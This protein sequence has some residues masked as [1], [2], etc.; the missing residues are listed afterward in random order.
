MTWDE[1]EL[2]RRF[3]CGDRAGFDAV[4]ERYA[5]RVM[6]FAR[7]L[8]GRQSEAEDLVQEVFLAA[9][10]ARSTFQGRS[11]LLTWL[12]G[13]AARRWRDQC[14][15]HHVET[16]S[17]FEEDA[18]E[19]RM[20][21]TASRCSLEEQV[22]RSLMLSRAVDG[23]E[24]PFR[25][26]LLLVASQGLTYREA[27]EALGE[28]VGTVKWRVFEAMRRVRRLMGAGEDEADAVQA[29]DSGTNGLSCGR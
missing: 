26:A 23:L 15:R 19:S 22:I 6:G 16:V 10:T 14:R 9:Y 8:S 5:A 20:P 12:L 21:D 13:I 25:E 27:A 4:Y 18:P 28:P 2:A 7:R 3:R 24:P 1:R 29:T 11:S 17:T